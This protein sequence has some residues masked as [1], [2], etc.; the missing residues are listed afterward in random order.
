L[1]FLTVGTQKPFDRLVKVVD[2][3]ASS[4]SSCKIIGQIGNSS[5]E[6]RNMSWD[7]R[8]T[9]KRY[10]EYLKSA[11]LVISHLGTGTVLSCIKLNI[12]IIAM[13]RLAKYGEHRNDHQMNGIKIFLNYPNVNVVESEKDLLTILNNWD[14]KEVVSLDNLEISDERKKLITHIKDFI[15]S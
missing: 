3:W 13:P 4:Q 5:Y 15:D 8:I 1:I 9:L 14:I 11:D 7:K 6:P 10:N 2:E 12:P